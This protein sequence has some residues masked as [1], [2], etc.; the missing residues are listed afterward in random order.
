ML[1]AELSTDMVRW[2]RLQDAILDLL[3]ITA[4]S[5]EY[6]THRTQFEQTSTAIPTT[7]HTTQAARRK[8][9]RAAIEQ[10]VSDIVRRAKDIETL[11]AAL[12][13]KDD[14]GVR[15]TR[16]EEL[17]AEM[18]VA[19]REY[20]EALGQAEELLGELKKVLRITLGDGTERNITASLTR[21]GI[22][23]S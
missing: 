21:L 1:S 22:P 20:K 12:P 11:I 14:S 9:Y 3:T 16:L 2:G 15:A 4:S 7:L 19:N 18:V 23:Q 13:S 17:Q 5:I 10:F 8:D 6:I